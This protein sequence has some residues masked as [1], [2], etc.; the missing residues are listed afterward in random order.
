PLGAPLKARY[1][2]AFEYSDCAT[3][4]AR[5]VVLN[6]LDADARGAV[7]RTRTRCLSADRTDRWTLVLEAR[8]RREVASARVLINAT[9]PWI[10][11][12]ARSVLR[13]GAPE[14]LRLDKGS[15]IVVRRLFGHD[16]GYVFQTQDRRIVFALPFE[17]DFTLIGTTD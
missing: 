1:R 7:I 4:D 2:R 10:G 5:L 6:A 14:H 15:H 16:R 11:D 3:D 17:H 12:F 8:G 13:E 9:G